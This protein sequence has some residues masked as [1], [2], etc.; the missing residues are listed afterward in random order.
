[1]WPPAFEGV[2]ELSR[3]LRAKG[4]NWATVGRALARSDTLMDLRGEPC[5]QATCW[6]AG[7]ALA[8]SAT[9]WHPEGE[10]LLA[11]ATAAVVVA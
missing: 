4:S 8:R 1:M 2:R 3:S 6:T 5:S 11:S 9:C 7:R 10:K